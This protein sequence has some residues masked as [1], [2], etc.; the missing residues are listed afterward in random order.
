MFALLGGEVGGGFV[1]DLFGLFEFFGGAIPVVAI[2]EFEDGVEVGLHLVEV[3]RAGL[4]V[5]ASGG[6]A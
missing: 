6:A 3:A 4:A 5:R 2:P 1:G